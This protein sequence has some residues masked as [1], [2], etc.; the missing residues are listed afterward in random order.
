MDYASVVWWWSCAMLLQQ[1]LSELGHPVTTALHWSNLIG[2]P[3]FR[4]AG[5]F[6]LRCCMMPFTF[7]KAHMASPSI[8]PHVGTSAHNQL[9]ASGLMVRVE[10]MTPCSCVGGA[11]RADRSVVAY[12]LPSVTT[13]W[14]FH[15]YLMVYES[16]ASC[17]GRWRQG[18]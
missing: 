1:M 7:H 18:S 17:W 6:L 9:D 3:A 11:E 8:A 10:V 4:A 15:L 13:C 14:G 2:L 16:R 12:N 5:K